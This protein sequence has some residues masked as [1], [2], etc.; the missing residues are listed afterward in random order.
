MCVYMKAGYSGLATG[1]RKLEKWHNSVHRKNILR[2]RYQI[3]T[4]V[5]QF[6][7]LR[8]ADALTAE[9]EVNADDMTVSCPPAI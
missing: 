4:L 7:Q 1:R 2:P 6:A 5:P 8:H 9:H 3:C